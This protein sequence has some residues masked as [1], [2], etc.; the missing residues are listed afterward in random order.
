MP[1]KPGESGNP[2]GRVKGSKDKLP[3]M[4]KAAINKAFNDK[5]VGGAEYLV[6]LALGDRHQQA[7]FCQLLGKMVPAE[8]KVEGDLMGPVQ[9]FVVT[10]IQ[11][12][13]GS[14]RIELRPEQPKL[15]A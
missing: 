8:L 15:D 14:A 7:A 5:R 3:A 13:P 9:V 6:K 2:G 12:S 1:Y 10:G 11:G 4:V